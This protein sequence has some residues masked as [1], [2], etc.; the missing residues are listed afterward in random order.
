MG[1]LPSCVSLNAACPSEPLLCLLDRT[2]PKGDRAQGPSGSKA[3]QYFVC[4]LGLNT[5]SFT[6]G[7]CCNFTRY[8]GITLNVDV[9]HGTSSHRVITHD[10]TNTFQ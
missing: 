8:S 6:V 9:T 5:D 4:T 1:L 10:H 2:G 7:S 3:Q